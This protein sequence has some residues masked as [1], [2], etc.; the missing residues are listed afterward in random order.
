MPTVD[1]IMPQYRRAL[2]QADQIVAL[3]HG[4]DLARSTPC[5]GWDLQALLNH[6]IGQNHGFAAAVTTGDAP[7]SVNARASVT[8]DDLASQWRRSADQVLAAFAH[9]DNDAEVLLIEVNEDSTF[10]V[11]AAIRMH[12]LD[13]VVHTWDL[14]RSVGTSFRPEDELLD[15]VAAVAERVPIGASR[16]RLGAAFA[17]PVITEQPDPWLETLALLG[18]QEAT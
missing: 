18:R 15:I 17:P 14:A 16:T 11:A 9:A 6:M 1:D 3:V 13:T 2:A 12:L 7:A 10:S 4:G 8:A 5:T